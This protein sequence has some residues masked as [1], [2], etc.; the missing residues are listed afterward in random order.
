MRAIPRSRNM[1]KP[2]SCTIRSRAGGFDDDG[3]DPVAG[4]PSEHGGEAGPGLDRS[5]PRTRGQNAPVA[6]EGRAGLCAEQGA[7]VR[8]RSWAGYTINMFEFKFRQGTAG[9]PTTFGADDLACS[10]TALSVPAVGKLAAPAFIAG[11]SYG[12]PP[13]HDPNR[14]YGATGAKSSVSSV[15]NVSSLRI[16]S[17]R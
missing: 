9:C 3:S 5:A 1:A 16:I 2:T 8:R 14:P 12:G 11:R 6:G 4:D 13:S 7:C 10:A 17:V 15:P